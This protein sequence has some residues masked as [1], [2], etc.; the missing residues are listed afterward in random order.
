VVAIVSEPVREILLPTV[1]KKLFR[2]PELGGA[3][4]D[5]HVTQPER[6]QKDLR[7]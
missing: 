2:N 6:L 5:N 7:D 3:D 4:F 1:I